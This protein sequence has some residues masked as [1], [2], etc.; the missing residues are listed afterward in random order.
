MNSKN[1]LFVLLLSLA[2]PA[3]L[4]FGSGPMEE[5]SGAPAGEERPTIE[6]F[7]ATAVGPGIP[8]PQ[9]YLLWDYISEAVNADFEVTVIP[10]DSDAWVTKFNGRLASDDVPNVIGRVF[11]EK[12]L[13]FLNDLGMGGAILNVSDNLDAL[14]D[15][16]ETYS[17]VDH[18]VKSVS[19]GDGNMYAFPTISLTNDLKKWQ[20]IIRTDV[21]DEVGIAVAD[22]V[23]LDDL[24]AALM[25]MTNN[26]GAPSYT[27]R[28][29]YLNF[30]LRSGYLFNVEMRYFWDYETD[31]YYHP[32]EAERFRDFVQWHADLYAAGVMH[33]D[34]Q[35]MTD[36]QWEELIANDQ[37][38][39]II[40]NAGKADPN[41]A[42]P[43]DWEY[44]N[45]PEINGNAYKQPR[46]NQIDIQNDIYAIGAGHPQ[47]EEEAAL[48]FM[49]FLYD[50]DNFMMIDAGIEGISYTRED[51]NTPAGIRWLIQIYGENE[52]TEAP[53]YRDHGIQALHRV[54]TDLNK[55]LA[56]G[57]GE[58]VQKQIDRSDYIVNAL[59]GFRPDNKLISFTEEELD[60]KKRYE[61]AVNT[62]VDENVIA[63]IEGD[64]DMSEWDTFVADVKALR[65]YEELNRVHETALARFNGT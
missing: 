16:V 2:T 6:F 61:T 46:R 51:P 54:T 23:T 8:H 39:F 63:F 44:L 60:L 47:A 27:N 42:T 13:V 18:Y 12:P 30:L 52:G 41:S 24:T 56:P 49:N 40:E 5:G 21:L 33:P 19:A 53:S 48:R 11:V 37:T 17:K 1:L 9:E 45:Y 58:F 43:G 25:A 65:G 55:R 7:Y 31:T 20:I 29:G 22:I 28:N 59:G 34:W 32:V 35:T 10:R 15:Y 26:R 62:F 38:F 36:P 14:P 3:V 50:E 4:V 57:D 64:R